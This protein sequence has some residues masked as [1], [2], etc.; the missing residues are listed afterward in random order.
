MLKKFVYLTACSLFTLG[1]QQVAAQQAPR[2]SHALPSAD[3]GETDDD[4][5]EEGA[6]GGAAESEYID[7]IP[8]YA[9]FFFEVGSNFNFLNADARI[10]D[11]IYGGVR[12]YDDRLL[13]LTP[14]GSHTRQYLG[15]DMGAS[16][17]TSQNY[18]FSNFS[19]FQNVNPTQVNAD[20]IRYTRKYSTQNLNVYVNQLS[21]FVNPNTFWSLNDKGN[22]R[23]GVGLHAEM[24]KMNYRFSYNNTTVLDTQDIT[25]SRDTF[26]ARRPLTSLQDTFSVPNFYGYFG[27]SIPFHVE[28]KYIRARFKMTFGSIVLGQENDAI[29][30][31]YDMSVQGNANSLAAPIL[32][33][34]KFFYLF[35]ASLTEPHT[36]ISITANIRGT[37]PRNVPVYNVLLTKRFYLP[38]LFKGLAHMT[39]SAPTS[40][41]RE[42]DR[43]HHDH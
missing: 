5:S 29:R 11:I 24:Y 27:I 2:E 31:Y 16:Y 21:L 20:S 32:L 9:G 6:K 8:R 38:K 40:E 30:G 17:F 36:N 10:E 18:N 22:I 43:H 12:Y 34:N 41:E 4:G 23:I 25:V 1:V 3:A 26:Y 42:D 33:T 7:T 15:I 35:D 19:T 13:R 28:Q 37:F 14:H 39:T